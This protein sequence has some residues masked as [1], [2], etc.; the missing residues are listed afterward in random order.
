MYW[1]SRGWINSIQWSYFFF[2][3]GGG[4]L[5]FR[6]KETAR[7]SICRFLRTQCCPWTAKAF[8][9]TRKE[10]Q[11]KKKKIR[12]QDSDKSITKNGWHQ[13]FNT[14]LMDCPLFSVCS[15]ITTNTAFHLSNSN[16][17]IMDT[18]TRARPCC[19]QTENDLRTASKSYAS[20]SYIRIHSLQ[21]SKYPA[22]KQNVT[23]SHSPVTHSLLHS[24][25]LARYCLFL[26]R[27]NAF[28]WLQNRMG[29]SR[30]GVKCNQGISAV[31][32]LCV[33]L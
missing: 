31:S 28:M 18:Q 21:A 25:A 30:G 26:R 17:K 2:L 5:S 33:C 16:K 14:E 20:K 9:R 19:A 1:P 6:C 29:L 23:F 8:T 32:V 10:K 13:A 15:I 4:S 11:K 3:G 24:S 22:T 12:H 7:Q 27:R